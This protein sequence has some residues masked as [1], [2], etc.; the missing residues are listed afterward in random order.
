MHGVIYNWIENYLF[1]RKQLVCYNGQLS[2]IQNITCGIPQ[3][4]ILGPLLFLLYINDIPNSTSKA[5]ILSFADDTTLIISHHNLKHLYKLA[6][7]E[8]D[9]L[10][11]WLCV[12]KLCLNKN[13]TKFMLIYPKWKHY[14]E[15][16][17]QLKINNQNIEHIQGQMSDG[18]SSAKFLGLHID[19]HLTWKAHIHITNNKISTSVFAINKIKNFLPHSALKTLY[20]SLVHPHLTYGLL[21]WGQSIPCSSLNKTF[22]LQKR[23]IRIINR[24]AYTSHTDP[25]FKTSKILK[26]HDLYILQ[27]CLFTYDFER[28]QL[29]PSVTHYFRHTH[30][31]HPHIHTRQSHL[32]HQTLARNTFIA[33]L[34]QHKISHIWNQNASNIDMNKSKE[35]NKRKM[36]QLI[37]NTYLENV[38]CTNPYCKKCQRNPN[39][40]PVQPV[41][42]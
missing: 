23:A 11:K 7:E 12:N 22:L 29:P 36:K 15:T 41:T 18:S 35:T 21:A 42:L 33:N 10:Y 17:L 16:N 19:Q 30:D 3:G 1:E 27:A 20:Y 24:V 4:S 40:N 26:L 38:N 39:P 13:K 32:I 9:N 2:S 25:L 8:L 6:N 34:P 5:S 31:I 28:K 14:D 37:L